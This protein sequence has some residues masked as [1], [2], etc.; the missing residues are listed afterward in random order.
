MH[1]A[2]DEA[3]TEIAVVGLWCR[4]PGAASPR[5]FWSNLAAGREC[6]ATLDRDA[7][8]D[9]CVPAS[10][11]DDPRYVPRRGLLSEAADFDPEFF[12]MT[13]SEATLTDPQHRQ[14][15]EC[16]WLAL[17]D[18]GYVPGE[19]L[20]RVGIYAAQSHNDYRL[21][22]DP[23]AKEVSRKFQA[24]INCAAAHLAANVAYRLDLNGPALSVQTACSSSLVAVH[25]ACQ[26]LQMRDCDVALAGGASVGW[27]QHV[28]HLYVDGGIMSRDGHC[29]PFDENASGTVRG[30][31]VGVV[32]L[33][34]LSAALRDR[35]TIRAVIRGSAINN[36]G[37]RKVG[38]TAP[39]GSGQIE[40]IRTALARAGCDAGSIH[41]VEAHGTGTELGDA[42]ELDAL[43]EALGGLR[44]APLH[45]GSVKSNIG[46]LDAA[47]GIAGFIKAV[48]MLERGLVPPTLHFARRSTH[49]KATTHLEI[50]E[51]LTQWPGHGS[52]RCGV[53]AFGLG[54]TNAHVVLEKA[55]DV[56]AVSHAPVDHL[57]VLS[58]AS[59]D[60][61]REVANDLAAALGEQ[62]ALEV[63]DIANTLARGRRA[64]RWR[65]AVVSNSIATLQAQ[66]ARGITV[67]DSDFA[68]R[69]C[70]FVFP[71]RISPAIV[72]VLAELYQT[73]AHFRRRFDMSAA[74]LAVATGHDH[75]S[76]T[77]GEGHC[78]QSNQSRERLAFCAGYAVAHRLF[79]WGAR[80]T[81]ALGTG[82]GA[83]VAACVSGVLGLENAS[84]LVAERTSETKPDNLA[85]RLKDK[86]SSMMMGAARLRWRCAL[87]QQDLTAA[88]ALSGAYW[89]RVFEAGD[90]SGESC[91][92]VTLR[93]LPLDGA[94]GS[95]A[96][97][98]P[99]SSGRSLLLSILGEGWCEGADVDWLKVYEG[100]LQ[101]RVPLPHP[102]FKRTRLAPPAKWVPETAPCSPATPVRVTIDDAGQAEVVVT[103]L[104]DD[105]LGITGSRPY[106]CF[107][108]L[109]GCSITVLDL[110]EKIAERTGQELP[111]KIIFDA[112]NLGALALA[113]VERTPAASEPPEIA[114]KVEFLVTDAASSPPIRE[115]NSCTAAA[116]VSERQCQFSVFFFSGEAPSEPRPGAYDLVLEAARFA[117]TNGF[118]A[119]WLPERH[120]HRFGGLFPAPAALAAA[121]SAV[122]T[123]VKIRAG[124]VVLP[125]HD[126]LR[127]VEEWSVVDN[128]SNGRVGVSFAPGFHPT[129]FVLRPTA[130]K[131]RRAAFW[132]AVDLVRSLWSGGRQTGQDG[133]GRNTTVEILPRPLQG[134]L[135]TWITASESVET[136]T[137]AGEIGA[138]VLTGLMTHDIPQLQSK[139]AAYRTAFRAVRP[140]ADGRVT[141]M[142]HAYVHPDACAVE[143]V[144]R[145]H[146]RGYLDNHL[147]FASARADYERIT[148]LR[149]K[150]RA[151]LL[152]HAVVRYLDG[153]SLIGTPREC[154]KTATQLADIGVDEIACL[155]DFGPSSGE[156]LASLSEIARL[157][158]GLRHEGRRTVGGARADVPAE[159]ESLP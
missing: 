140:L 62:P 159:Q 16:S 19:A 148:G 99:P 4:L 134:E 9:A 46:H 121:I 133:L 86:T 144:G 156:A 11:A 15:L 59:S 60:A 80:P 125:L 157:Q 145:R 155:V 52:R 111:L 142:V 26:A 41:Y 122:T 147:D 8:L 40:V 108:A 73:D 55:P 78:Y 12:G 51:A 72:P 24:D 132:P 67:T 113:L 158:D 76:P 43:S 89:L 14:F 139:I 1:G 96:Q 128:L 130:F 138:S 141:V 2:C 127:V 57:V 47:A 70:A 6:I 36:D 124:S 153:R 98:A 74:K 79:D 21:A 3:G 17:A 146:L 106:D 37:R 71:A 33:K 92:P 20:G 61:V 104:V 129:D 110:R 154:A 13:P 77:F 5:E 63:A 116:A 91:F 114:R 126:P 50:P 68:D 44:R 149:P 150:D 101:R 29:R 23:I 22:C 7:L 69:Q 66:L 84:G 34:P 58:A 39:A 152:N 38:Y 120:F 65:A 136:F 25:L 119:I 143:D 75:F 135:P 102:P 81:G 64:Q 35:D 54:G 42:I 32:V 27:P 117:D 105:T 112:P 115:T 123:R 85:E 82:V 151:A 18:A 95:E 48:L 10:L 109:G 30:E 131:T 100:T 28:G 87:S 90:A 45:V 83:C 88:E 97:I 53:S 107:F 137:R 93:T 56:A 103:R 49:V 31:G 94:R 118:E